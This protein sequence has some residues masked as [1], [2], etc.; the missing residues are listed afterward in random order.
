[1][2]GLQV[3]RV[4]GRGSPQL[5]VSYRPDL[6]WRE[7]R[8]H[9]VVHIHDLRFA[10][11][12]T[13]IG[14]RVA[15]RPLLFHTRGLIFHSGSQR[16]KRLA[17][18][19]YFGPL[20]RL[21]GARTVASSEADRA[22]LLR[23]APYLAKLTYSYPNALPLKRLLSLE[24]APIRGRVVSIGRIVPNKALTDLVR[25]LS[26]IRD[27]EWSLLLAGE[28]NPEELARIKAL[29]DELGVG[30]RVSYLLGFAEGELPQLLGS[31]AVAAF[32]SK[33]EG[34]GLALLEAMAAGVPLV[35]RRIPAHELL[36]GAENEELIV[37]FDDPN[38]VAARIRGLLAANPR[39]LAA[40]TGKLRARAAEFDMDRLHG[41]IQ[42]LY[43]RLGVRA[44]GRG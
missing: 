37:D 29:A 34:F 42:G 2:D 13:L 43:S 14:A 9:D 41:Q 17:M 20:L 19:F 30:E 3:V 33:G 38:A 16:W 40:L 23:D 1:L 8:R 25:G 32:P 6:I 28:P 15:R 12:T 27:A 11:A 39:E 35:A 18:R 22:L 31:A 24:R 10:M 4:P 21:G 44:H 26:R 5:A 36:L 7:I